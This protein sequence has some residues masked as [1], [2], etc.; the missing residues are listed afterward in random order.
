MN[1]FNPKTC[2]VPH[3]SNSDCRNLQRRGCVL[4][5]RDLTPLRRLSSLRGLGASKF[6]QELDSCL[7]SCKSSMCKSIQ[8]RKRA[9]MAVDERSSRGVNPT[10]SVWAMY[11][12]RQAA[13]LALGA[14]QGLGGDRDQRCRSH[15]QGRGR[16]RSLVQVAYSAGA[17]SGSD[18]SSNPRSNHAITHS[19]PCC[20]HAG[21]V[22]DRGGSGCRAPRACRPDVHWKPGR[23]RRD[24]RALTDH[25]RTLTGPRQVVSLVETPPH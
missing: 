23:S 22:F 11:V 9:T 24:V 5:A 13:V 6:K 17:P 25:A 12:A 14:P 1:R 8:R 16:Q 15:P 10:G 7:G 18:R 3:C 19:L 4:H 21:P 2:C 20:P